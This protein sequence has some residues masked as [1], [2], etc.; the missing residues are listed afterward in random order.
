MR[1][2]YSPAANRQKR[3]IRLI[4]LALAVI[5]VFCVVCA[6]IVAVSCR[7]E[8]KLYE[9]TYIVRRGDS[10]WSISAEFCPDSMSRQDWIAMVRERNGITGSLIRPGQRIV[11]FTAD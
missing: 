3:D 5:T 2:Y 7:N 9:D 6:I 11:V 10:L 4:G 8:T 1:V